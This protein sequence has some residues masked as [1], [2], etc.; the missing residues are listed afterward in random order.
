MTRARLRAWKCRQGVHRFQAVD[1]W[2]SPLV[3]RDCPHESNDQYKQF[4]IL[5]AEAMAPRLKV[6]QGDRYW[7]ESVQ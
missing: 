4:A 1:Y 7:R 3:C 2:P 5:V 6:M